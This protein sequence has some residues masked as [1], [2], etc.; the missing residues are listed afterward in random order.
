MLRDDS[1]FVAESI[2]VDNI[3]ESGVNIR[4]YGKRSQC[5]KGEA[6]YSSFSIWQIDLTEVE[7][8]F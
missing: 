3:Q 1:H 2:P 8:S 5:T 7:D 4:C 6:L